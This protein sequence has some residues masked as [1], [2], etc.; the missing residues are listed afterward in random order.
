[1][2]WVKRF[3]PRSRMG[4]DNVTPYWLLISISVSIH[5]PAWGATTFHL[6]QRVHLDVSIH[7]PAWG[8]TGNMFNRPDGAS[9]FNP[10]SRMGSD[11][12]IAWSRFAIRCFNPRSRMGSDAA[13]M[14]KDLLQAVVSIHAPAWGATED[15]HLLG[16]IVM[17]QS[18]LPHGERLHHIQ[19]TT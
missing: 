19:S 5:A 4:S 10:R 13:A 14:G 2:T 6:L 3:N 7:A 11:L 17:F 16:R 18:T 15:S 12:A 9:S 1:M 8:A